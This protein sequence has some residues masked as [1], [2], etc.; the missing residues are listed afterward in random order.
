MVIYHP[1][2]SLKL[3]EFGIDVP[4]LDQRAQ[5]TWEYFNFAPIELGIL[6][7]L[8][9]EQLELVHG[10]N[11]IESLFD[12]RLV[13]VV[14]ACYERPHL[15]LNVE[16][17]E[18]LREALFLQARGT[19]LCLEQALVGGWSF[20]LGGGMH[21]ARANRP[22][23]Y[24]M[25]HD[26]AIGL[27]RLLTTQKISR[28][29]VVDIDAHKGDGT[30]EIFRHDP[31]VFTLSAHMAE[32]WP[33]G[34]PDYVDVPSTIDI[35]IGQKQEHLYLEKLRRGLDEL[36]LCA[37]D[38]DL[39]V[40]VAGADPYEHDG[41]EGSRFLKLTLKQLAERDELVSSYCFKRDLPQAWLMAGGYGERS[42]EVYIQ[43]ISLI[44]KAAKKDVPLGGP[45]VKA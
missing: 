27:R 45:K 21:H 30:A 23:G 16:Q 12:E 44:K 36:S 8:G 41:L 17:A 11:Y 25:I 13:A 22:A 7:E 19:L 6:P 2:F 43:G 29:W 42:H 18:A 38:P 10:S 39:V 34:S 32:G 1:K 20:F 4:L 24:C 15:Q 26:F 5:K 37:P 14:K 33:F 35:P 31:N 28:A 9:R 40:V 3:D